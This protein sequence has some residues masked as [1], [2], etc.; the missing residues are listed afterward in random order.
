MPVPMLSPPELAQLPSGSLTEHTAICMCAAPLELVLAELE[1]PLHCPFGLVGHQVRLSP[2]TTPGYPALGFSGLGAVTVS[3]HESGKVA[4]SGW[5]RAIVAA[6]PAPAML[7]SR[8]SSAA[9]ED[10]MHW[11]CVPR[12]DSG[13][14]HP[15]YVESGSD[16]L[17]L[18]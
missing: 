9:A 2:T 10:L 5:R 8:G 3:C 7:S 14:G 18:L 13:E 11:S 16:S 6:L 1:E 17:C 15:S 12:R 4:E